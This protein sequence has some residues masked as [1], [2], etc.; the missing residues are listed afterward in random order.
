MLTGEAEQIPLLPLSSLL[1]R[2]LFPFHVAAPETV[3]TTMLEKGTVSP[4]FHSVL[5]IT[6]S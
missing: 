3:I 5:Q 4:M 2:E 6:A 1:L